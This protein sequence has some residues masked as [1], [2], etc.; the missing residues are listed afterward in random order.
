[1]LD[2]YQN[3]ARPFLEKVLSEDKIANFDRDKQRLPQTAQLGNTELAAC[4]LGSSGVGKS[5]LINALVGGAQPVVPS[6]G[7]G[8]L[9]AQALVVRYGELPGFEVEYHGPSRILR[10]IFGLQQ[11]FKTELGRPHLSG[12]ILAPEPD[13][14][15]DELPENSPS[16]TT[17]GNGDT[18]VSDSEVERRD[19]REQMRRRAQLLIT[20]AQDEDCALPYLLDCLLDAIGRKRIWGTAPDSRDAARLD[21]LRDAL[22]FVKEGKRFEIQD[23]AGDGAAFRKSLNDHATGYLAPLIKTLLLHWPSALLSRGATLVDLPGVGVLRDVHKDITRRWIRERANA[24][25]LVVDHRG[26]TESLA[27]ALKRSEFLNTLLY[28]ADEP[29]DDPIVLVAVTR[30]DDLAGERYR[31]DRSRRKYEYFQ[32]AVEEAKARL[33]N[34]LQHRLD[35]IWLQDANASDARKQVVRN[36]LATLQVHPISAPEYVKFLA[37]DEDDRSF[38]KDINQTGVPDLIESITRLSEDRRAKAL[39][40][41][42][43][44]S[45]LFRDG[46]DTSLRLIEAQWSGES[47]ADEEVARLREDLEVFIRPL[48]E[49]LA[50]RQGGYRTF[51]KKHVPQR[52]RDLIETAKVTASKDIDRYLKRLWQAHWATLRASVRRGGRYSGASDVNLPTVFALSFEEPV[53]EVWGKKILND[54]RNETKD[55][56]NDCVALVDQVAD[57]ALQQGARVQPKVIEAQREAIRADAKNLQSVGHE[58]VKEMRDEAKAQLVNAIEAPIKKA[59]NDFIRK[60]LDVGPGVKMRILS[61][62]EQLADKVTD[63]AEEPATRILSKCFKEVE[64]E[65]LGAFAEHQD[66]LDSMVEAIVNSQ[67]KYLERSDTQKRRR[68]LEE[69]EDVLQSRPADGLAATA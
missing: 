28:S 49:E 11:M 30:I 69:L 7:V 24:L 5:T 57:W 58:M 2:W 51:L 34:E 56:A 61:L 18:E 31:Q 36:V 68:V 67:Q 48:R 20:G 53:A 19:R 46:L 54:I 10:T 41:V 16:P 39:A 6:G 8:P 38:L 12:E 35:E 26:M 33:R 1:L 4:F 47:H 21:G 43:G 37:T 60:N 9:T 63:A 29:E 59:C 65:I 25:V 23:L 45:A 32:E 27:E 42:R 66:P 62:Y 50:N 52:I 17:D 40:R 3:V 22:S 64:K 44:R 13:L 14:D 55:Y 15:D